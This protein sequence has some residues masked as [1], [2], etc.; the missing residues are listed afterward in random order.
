LASR[1]NLVPFNR[2]GKIGLLAFS[3]WSTSRVTQ[4][5]ASAS[6]V[7]ITTKA[8]QVSIIS[9][10]ILSQRSPAASS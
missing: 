1:K 7:M 2:S 9:R 5:D 6:G 3:A 4:S 8:A 10:M